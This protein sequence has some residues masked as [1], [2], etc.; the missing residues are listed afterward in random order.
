MVIVCPSQTISFLHASE[1][2]LVV[3]LSKYNC[4]EIKSQGVFPFLASLSGV[5]VHNTGTF[6][7]FS[8]CKENGR[9][10]MAEQRLQPIRQRHDK[11]SPEPTGPQRRMVSV[12]FCNA[13]HTFPLF[14]LPQ[15]PETDRSSTAPFEQPPGGRFTLLG[16][17]KLSV[18]FIKCFQGLPFPL[19][20]NAIDK[21][22]G[23]IRAYVTLSIKEI[24]SSSLGS[25]W[26]ENL[27][28]LVCAK[29]FDEVNGETMQGAVVYTTMQLWKFMTCIKNFC[30]EKLMQT[31][32]KFVDI[33]IYV[34]NVTV[35]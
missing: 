18:H 21:A 3:V 9:R 14:R 7:A 4:S 1:L 6:L 33:V 15:L 28:L 12:Q 19:R 16:Y 5:S 10:W 24:T 25:V 35:N 26:S 17:S 13:F 30:G 29:T 2:L 34:I 27:H 8:R 22:S 32:C 31:N 11:R 23:G 20:W